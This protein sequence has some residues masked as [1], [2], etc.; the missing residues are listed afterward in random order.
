MDL[1]SGLTRHGSGGVG[2]I[3][4]SEGFVRLITSV[5]VTQGLEKL[6]GI[7]PDARKWG[8]LRAAIFRP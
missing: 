3:C 1:E 7:S 5:Q 8:Q 6:A 2:L 4:D